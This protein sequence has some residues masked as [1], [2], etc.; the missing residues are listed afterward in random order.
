MG[1]E[2]A[3]S[4][5]DSGSSSR[6]RKRVGGRAAR[7]QD[8][9]VDCTNRNVSYIHNYLLLHLYML[10]LLCAAVMETTIDRLSSVPPPPAYPFCLLAC[11]RPDVT[12]P[13]LALP[14][15]RLAIYG[16]TADASCRCGRIRAS[17]VMNPR[18]HS[19]CH[20]LTAVDCFPQA[21]VPI[22]VSPSCRTARLARPIRVTL[23]VPG[24]QGS[25]SHSVR[26]LSSQIL[27]CI[28]SQRS[29]TNSGYR[30]RRLCELSVVTPFVLKVDIFRCIVHLLSIPIASPVLC[31]TSPAP[32]TCQPCALTQSAWKPFPSVQQCLRRSAQP[33]AALVSFYAILPRWTG[34]SLVARRISDRHGLS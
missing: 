22:S 20:L 14:H 18:P 4:S 9:A 7:K 3:E 32:A 24:L 1:G 19:H 33:C 10:L 27:R 28:S 34:H 21:S 2:R 17:A 11:H 16:I 23:P 26:R 12:S 8:A 5:S 6:V 13:T 30:H 15:R 25:D 31:A 29:F